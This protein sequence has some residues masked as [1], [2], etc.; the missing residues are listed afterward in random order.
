[1]DS[2]KEFIAQCGGRNIILEYGK[3]NPDDPHYKFIHQ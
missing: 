2:K 3:Y 1:M